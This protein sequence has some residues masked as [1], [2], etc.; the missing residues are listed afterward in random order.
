M[1]AAEDVSYGYSDAVVEGVSLAAEPGEVLAIIGP[2]G[3]GKTTLLRLLALFDPPDAGRITAEGRDVWT[4]SD[5]E[6]REIRQR[7]GFVFQDRS[8]FSTSVAHNAAYGLSV[9]RSWPERLRQ[10]L[11]GLVGE[12]SVPDEV[13]DALETVGLEGKVDRPARSLS[14]GEAQRVAFARALAVGPDVLL[15]DEPTSNLDPRNTAVIEE[16]VL[17]ARDRDIAVVIATHDMQQAERIADRVAVLLDGTVIERGPA[18]RVFEDPDDDR[19]RQF[20]AGELV[21]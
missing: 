3:T 8:L 6:R 9:R 14:A 19:A 12:P 16:A 10:W 13:L 15:L 7:I 5:R 17:A 18:D 2:S 20:V 11:A 4:L 1:I 21:Y